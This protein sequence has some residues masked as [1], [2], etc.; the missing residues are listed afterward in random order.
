MSPSGVDYSRLSSEVDW[1]DCNLPSGEGETSRREYYANYPFVLLRLL[2]GLAFTG[3]SSSYMLYTGHL[4]GDNGTMA[5]GGLL[6]AFFTWFLFILYRELRRMYSEP[7]IGVEPVSVQDMD[8][9]H[10]DMTG[11]PPRR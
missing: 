7:D 8:K 1:Q 3:F 11:L 6:L 5:A 9:V 2:L 4:E 10:F